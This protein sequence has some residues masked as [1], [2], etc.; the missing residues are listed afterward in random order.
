MNK[1]GVVSQIVR[2]PVKSMAGTSVTTTQLGWHGLAGDRRFAFRRIK[3]RS[4]FPWLSASKL[5][6]LLLY[7]PIGTDH[8]SGEPLPTHVRTPSGEELELTALTLRKEIAA[9]LGE[10]VELIS[11]RN[12]IFDDANISV[13]TTATIEDICQDAGVPMDSRRFRPNIIIETAEPAQFGED[14]WVGGTLWFGNNSDVRV[15]VTAGDLR[16][17]I[18]NLDPDSARQESRVM[19]SV[20]RRNNNIAGVYG[21][22][23]GI[24]TVSVGQEVFFVPG[25]SGLVRG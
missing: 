5:P 13:I 23:V 22:A 18:I 25:Q 3:D 12:G 7:H 14:P 8:S 1:V 20:V 4:G 15:A 6:E 24:G 16:C 9:H 17:M 19:K 11:L 10:D 2:Y 21:T